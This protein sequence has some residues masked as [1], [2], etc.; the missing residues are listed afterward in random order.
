MNSE[1]NSNFK[2][3]HI[4]RKKKNSLNLNKKYEIYIH[5]SKH[6]ICIFKTIIFS[7]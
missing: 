6:T 1:L 3:F 7:S 2:A 4:L 5:T